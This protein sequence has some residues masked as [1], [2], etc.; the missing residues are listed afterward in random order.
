MLLD[1]FRKRSFEGDYP[2]LVPR[3]GDSINFLIF[4]IVLGHSILHGGPG[5]YALQPWVFEVIAGFDK[6][7]HL[8]TLV[9]K[10][11]I[12]LHAGSSNL[13]EFIKQL[14]Y[15]KTKEELDIVVDKYMQI[16]N[17]SRWDQTA[18]ITLG[19]KSLLLWELVYEELVL[20]RRSQIKS[21][22]EGLEISGLLR[23]IK[24]YPDLCRPIFV[25]SCMQI[26]PEEL[27]NVIKND[28]H[29]DY[30]KQQAFK[31]LE[32]MIKGSSS[33]VL[34]RLLKF[35]TGYSNIPPWGLG[36]QIVIKYHADDEDK[37]YPEAMVCFSILYLP[38]VHSNEASF[39]CHFEKA[40]DVEGV[41]FSA[42]S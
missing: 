26:K 29:E 16:I 31:Y 28:E 5:F 12:P 9:T 33:S 7:E 30:E 39:I 34:S 3:R 32:I 8:M 4:G 14:D 38:T 15:V 25:S 22:Q 19:N 1:E 17:C 2:N 23:Y 24:D 37:I 20:K 27:L 21:I 35:A 11:D 40:L 6:P 18:T 41:G 13:L 42:S 36:R 10:D